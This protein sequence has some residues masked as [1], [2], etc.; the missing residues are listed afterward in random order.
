MPGSRVEF[1]PAGDTALVVQFGERVD[2]KL[3]ERVLRLAESV[4]AADLEGVRETVP[5]FRS[6]LVHYDPLRTRFD[7]LCERLRGLIDS[8]SALTV[9]S[10]RWS[11]PVCYE[12]RFAP[13]LEEV[14]ERT[15]HS[16]GEVISLH[17]S[18]VYHVYMVGFLPGYPYLGD[19]PEALALPRRE[20]PRVRVPPGSVAIATNLAAIYS[21]ES[22]GGWHLIGATPVRIFDPDWSPPALFAPGDRVSFVRIDEDEF[23]RLSADVAAGRFRLQA[24]DAGS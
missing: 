23:D 4:R 9:R 20:N 13:D 1:L 5:T 12:S 18:V 10:R 21:L 2:R 19:L 16:T 7:V 14:A 11:V 8:E 3:N 17:A 22:P 24:E 15:G 6:L